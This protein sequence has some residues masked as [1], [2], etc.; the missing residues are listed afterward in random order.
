MK[1]HPLQRRKETIERYLK[2]EKVQDICQAMACSKSFLYKWLHRYNNGDENWALPHARRPLRNP[3]RTPDAIAQEIVRL[4]K[5]L[6]QNRDLSSAPFIQ[7]AL[8][9]QGI[10]PLPSQRTIYRVLARHEKEV[11]KTTKTS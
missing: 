2:G 1:L 8:K 9:T 10:K 3:S 7:Q 5:E 6:G 4:K 11:G